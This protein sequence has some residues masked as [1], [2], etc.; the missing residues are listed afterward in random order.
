[1][2]KFKKKLIILPIVLLIASCS[3]ISSSANSLL[4]SDEVSSISQSVESNTNE[5]SELITD[6]TEDVSEYSSNNYDESTNETSRESTVT[7]ES[8]ISENDSSAEEEIAP[9][10]YLERTRIGVAIGNTISIGHEVYPSNLGAVTWKLLYDED[11]IFDIAD[12][13][14]IVTPDGQVT[15]NRYFGKEFL[16]KGTL[17]EF[18]VFVTLTVFFDY[19]KEVNTFYPSHTLGDAIGRGNRYHNGTTMYARQSAYRYEHY[20]AYDLEAGMTF[21]VMGLTRYN[22]DRPYFYFEFGYVVNNK[23][24]VLEH[25]FISS[26]GKALLLGY[27]VTIDGEYMVRTRSHREITGES[28]AFSYIKYTFWF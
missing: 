15:G 28:E 9:G 6:N 4:S 16:I 3:E 19:D 11:G 22:A 18:E 1:M 14:A 10:I 25:P 5:E 8:E 12:Y 27:D 20:Y 26:D 17:L 23:F 7:S 13:P 21:N 2:R 24:V